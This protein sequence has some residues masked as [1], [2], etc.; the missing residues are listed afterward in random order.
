MEH[1]HDTN[2]KAEKP[3]VP[4]VAATDDSPPSSVSQDQARRISLKHSITCPPDLEE[5]IRNEFMPANP[6]IESFSEAMVMLGR[7]VMEASKE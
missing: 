4:G 3:I 5:W 2:N 7:V 1:E 6:Q